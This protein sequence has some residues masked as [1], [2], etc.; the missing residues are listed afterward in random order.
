VLI[1]GKEFNCVEDAVIVSHGKEDIGKLVELG[2]DGKLDSSVLPEIKVDAGIPAGAIQYFVRQTAPDGWLKADGTA[3]SR[4][5]YADLF[6]AIGT[7]CGNGD[8][9]TTFNLP[10]LRG[11]FIRG[12]DDGRGLDTG[13]VLGSE[14]TGMI[15]SHSHQIKNLTCNIAYMSNGTVVGTSASNSVY[16]AGNDMIQETGGTETRPQNVALLACIKY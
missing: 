14:Q 9:S 7:I 4:T 5:Q 1:M 16:S 10:D 3:V 8:G 12:F 2:N 6:I 15:E 11:E 13:R